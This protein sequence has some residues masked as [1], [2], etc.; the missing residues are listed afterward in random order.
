MAKFDEDG[1]WAKKLDKHLEEQEQEV[2]A[3]C[4]AYED[5][6]EC[7]AFVSQSDYEEM[8]RDDIGDQ[9]MEEQKDGR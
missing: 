4:C 2:C 6:C 3:V 1:Y 5:E 7:E 9:K 8:M